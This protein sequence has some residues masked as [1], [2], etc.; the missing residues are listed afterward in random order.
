MLLAVAVMVSFAGGASAQMRSDVRAS[1]KPVVLA[2]VPDIRQ[3]RG[4]LSQVILDLVNNAVE[5]PADSFEKNRR[6]HPHMIV[7]PAPLE[8][9]SKLWQALNRNAHL[10]NFAKVPTGTEA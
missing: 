9:A 4:I 1:F 7:M 3:C 6:A 8:C 5:D 2:D 10:L